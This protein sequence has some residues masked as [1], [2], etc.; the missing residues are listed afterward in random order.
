MT[1]FST[2]STSS[3]PVGEKGKE[4]SCY[5]ENYCP[6]LII[7]VRNGWTGLEKTS[8]PSFRTIIHPRDKA[9]AW[10]EHVWKG[11]E[12]LHP[13]TPQKHLGRAILLILQGIGEAEWHIQQKWYLSETFRY[14]I[15]SEKFH[16]NES[17]VDPSVVFGTLI[18]SDEVSSSLSSFRLVRCYS[19]CPVCEL[20]FLIAYICCPPILRPLLFCSQRKSMFPPERLI[21]CPSPHFHVHAH[22]LAICTQT[23][24]SKHCGGWDAEQKTNC[25]DLTWVSK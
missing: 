2:V 20:L 10:G 15:Q 3:N 23:I 24:A 4:W 9:A 1:D 17:S 6:R 25:S 16:I 12:L 5:T 11:C 14:S 18:F 8:W 21:T 7:F 19:S 13:Q 22:V